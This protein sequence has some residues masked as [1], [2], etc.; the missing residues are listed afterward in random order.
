M[1]CN[2][3]LRVSSIV[4]EPNRREELNPSE[5][6]AGS[7]LGLGEPRGDIVCTRG[8]IVCAFFASRF[9]FARCAAPCIGQS[10]LVGP[11]RWISIGFVVVS[12]ALFLSS[13]SSSSSTSSTV[14]KW[15]VGELT[16]LHLYLHC[17]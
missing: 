11:A 7:S 3:P 5:R 6:L 1:V 17:K 2:A 14:V 8:G 4:R 16:S 15:W 9:L 10:R 13:S 12:F